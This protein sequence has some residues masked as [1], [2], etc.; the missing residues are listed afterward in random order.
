MSSQSRGHN[1]ENNGM[2]P[3]D[4]GQPVIDVAPL[5]CVPY[6]GPLPTSSR[7]ASQSGPNAASFPMEN[8]QSSTNSSPQPAMVYYT[9]AT[10]E[11]RANLFAATC[12]HSKVG[13]LLTGTALMG[14]VGPPIGAVD[15]LESDTEYFFRVSL[16]GV[17]KDAE[18]F[19][20]N[21]EPNGKVD[22]KGITLTGV[23]AVYKNNMVFKMNTPNLCPPGKFTISFQLPGPTANQFLTTFGSDGIFEASVKKRQPNDS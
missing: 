13:S 16:P 2:H 8:A 6:T 21:I 10:L 7:D 12:G 23:R 3:M 5:R 19:R 1:G 15:I 20:C 9:I 4:P 14:K 22:I 18:N 17:A 11:E